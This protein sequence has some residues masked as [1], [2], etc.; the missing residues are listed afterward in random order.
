[1]KKVAEGIAPS[2]MNLFK[3]CIETSNWPAIW[4][5]GE[6]TPILKKGDKHN[7]ENYRPIT[8]LSIIDK[9]FES[10][11]CKQITHYLISYRKNHNSE[12]ILV[13]LTEDWKHA[14]DRKELVTILSTDMSKAFDSLCHNLVIKK[15][16][17]YGFTNQSLDLIRSFLNDRYSRVKLGSIRSEWSKMSRGCPQGSSFGPL[18]WNLF[19][20]EITLL[21]KETNLFMYADD[22]QL[23]MY[24]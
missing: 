24:I 1:M 10:L 3:R 20:I 2:V 8:T 17:A 4:K 11:L 9:V 19:Q 14:I 22:H 18:L 13:R 15:L 7:V 16:K 5:R 12:T 6:L 23:S 21:V